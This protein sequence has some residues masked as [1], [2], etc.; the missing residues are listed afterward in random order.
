MA[1]SES[2]RNVGYY[3][4]VVHIK[5]ESVLITFKMKIGQIKDRSLNPNLASILFFV[6]DINQI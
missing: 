4:A 3:G 5:S 2:T 1:C 6:K